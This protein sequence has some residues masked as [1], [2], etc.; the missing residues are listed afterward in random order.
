MVLKTMFIYFQL[1]QEPFQLQ[2]FIEEIKKTSSSWIKT[3]D[4]CYNNFGWQNGYAAF[5][6]SSS[7][8]N[9]VIKYIARQKEHH[10]IKSFQEEYLLFLSEYGITYDEKYLW[11]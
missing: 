8:K 7:K 10:K 5:S 4:S 3:K 9:D 11:D 1:C 6:V 2:K